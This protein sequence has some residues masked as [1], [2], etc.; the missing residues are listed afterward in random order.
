MDRRA[1]RSA[2]PEEA[3]QFLVEAVA[4]R[5]RAP[6]VLVDGRGHIVAGT[7]MPG[8]VAG[9]ATA[10]RDVGQRRATP[11]T[12]DAATGGA[13]VSA[14]SFATRTG[15]LTFA[16]LSERWTGVG[17]AVRAVQRILG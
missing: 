5:S 7:G 2:H 6:V 15:T 4:D 12:V 1:K 13:D 16:A 9:L 3:L 8:E 11:E 10:A 17:D 14:R